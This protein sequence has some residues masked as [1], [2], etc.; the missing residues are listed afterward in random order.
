MRLTGQSCRERRPN[1]V[2]AVG[3][4]CKIVLSGGTT[5]N[6]SDIVIKQTQSV[7]IAETTA[8]APGFGSENIGPVF[9]HALPDVWTHLQKTGV[10]PGITVAYYD[11]AADDGSIVVHLGFDIGDQ[12]VPETDTIRVVDLPVI[13]VAS[14]VHRGPMDGIVPFYEALVR[15]IEDSGYR[16]AGR[17]RELYHE[18]HDDDP[19]RHVTE[20][21]MPIE[22]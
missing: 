19:A 21:Q 6:V 10:Q 8:T 9:D 17:S 4:R 18:W 22:R 11:W 13:T 20:L 5:V 1:T 3:P 2:T 15:W 7:R 16:L 14:V 12:Q